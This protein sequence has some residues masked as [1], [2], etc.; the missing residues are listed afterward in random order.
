MPLLL[1]SA[2]AVLPITTANVAEWQLRR[3]AGRVSPDTAQYDQYVGLRILLPQSGPIGFRSVEDG[4][5][6]R[7]LF[8]LQ[9]SLAPRLVVDSSATDFVIE[10]GPASGAGS[11]SADANFELRAIVDD[12][13]RV[14][15]RV[16]R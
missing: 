13:L 14:F 11:L 4:D 5:R 10:S 15:R 3:K 7:R 16:S 12:E 6:S 9:Y 8:F 2:L 1:Q